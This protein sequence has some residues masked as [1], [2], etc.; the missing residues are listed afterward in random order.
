VRSIVA[1]LLC[2]TSAA[3]ATPTR[4]QA[5][6]ITILSTMLA[7]AGIGEWGFAALVE[8]DGKRLLFD[9]GAQPDTVLKNARELHLD[10]AQVTDVVVSH[11]HGDHTGG[12]LALRRDLM[13]QRPTA[14]SRVHVGR[15]AFW[16]RPTKEGETNQLL[17]DKAAFEATGGTFIEHDRPIELLPGVWLTGPVPRPHPEHNWSDLTT[18]VT[19]T[20]TVEDTIPEDQ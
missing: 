5:L 2:W 6:K 8:V 19:P 16:S 7:D 17:S 12:L 13:K 14:L 4:T 3:L 18:V 9:T 11:N 20:G 1:I 10:L 15:G